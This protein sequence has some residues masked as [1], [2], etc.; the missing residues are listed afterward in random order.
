MPGPAQPGYPATQALG[1]VGTI[2]STELKSRASQGYQA[3][4]PFGQSGLEYQYESEL[5]GVPGQQQLEVNPEG[6]VVGSLKT[7]PAVPGDNLV[8]NIDTNLQQ[9][10]DNALA[11][12]ILALRKT[13]DSKCNNN[14]GCYP[15]ATG[16]AVIVMSPQ[17]GAVYAM[18]SYP[19]YN[20][21]GVGGRDLHR[22]VCGPFRPGQQR[23]ADQPGHRRPLHARVHVQAQHGHRRP[24]PRLDQPRPPPTTTPAPSR[25]PDASTTA[26]RASSTTARVMA[27]SAP[28]TCPPPSPCRATTSSTTWARMFYA[29]RT[30]PTGTPRSR[31]QAAQYGLGE[32]TGIDLPGE[33]HRARVD[34][35]TE[36][37]KLHAES[38]T[39]VPQHH[40]VH[41]GQ[42]RDGLR[43]GGDRDHPDRAGG[44]LLDV[45]Q[46]RHPLRP[47]GRRGH[48]LPVGQGGQAVHPQGHRARRPPAVDLPGPAHRVRRAWS[49]TPA[50]RP[51]GPFRASTSPAASPARPGRP[52]ARS[53]RSPPPG[54]WA[55][56]PT[57]DPQYV[58]V[59]VIDQAGYGA[60]A[61]GPGGPVRSSATWPPTRSPPPGIPPSPQAG[62]ADRPDTPPG[63]CRH[64]TH[65]GQVRRRHGHRHR[66]AGRRVPRPGR[67]QAEIRGRDGPPPAP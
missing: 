11:T 26:P 46:R 48:R 53:A 62:P 29:K 34:S 61:A 37:L 52:T 56:G 21:D 6:Q 51:T 14:A 66:T 2:N 17:T 13:P 33:S 65:P 64:A 44:G 18:S 55:S 4:D 57:A 8:T 47:A 7:T 63:T 39:G 58:V 22:R 42:R 35:P 23:A 27:A 43:P 60:A 30:R 50:A 10:A 28:S 15:A 41:R 45:R 36:R 38:P 1:Y 19:S 3:G 31:T 16:G 59:C 54:S 12:Q 25:F 9:V 20:P 5:R 49:R 40:L 32:L 67:G 24:R